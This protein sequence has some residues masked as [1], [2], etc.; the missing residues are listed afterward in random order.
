MHARTREW[1]SRRRSSLISLRL[2]IVDKLLPNHC[3]VTKVGF[4]SSVGEREKGVCL[5][6]GRVVVLQHDIQLT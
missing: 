3:K 6:P 5:A 4:G 1:H 2:E